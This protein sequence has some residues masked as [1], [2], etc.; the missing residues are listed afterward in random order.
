MKPEKLE[1]LV[2]CVMMIFIGAMSVDG[3]GNPIKFIREAKNAEHF[4]QSA[5]T[6]Y[7]ESRVIQEV[8]DEIE[9]QQKAKSEKVIGIPSLERIGE[10]LAKADSV[11]A[12][13]PQEA[14]AF[15]SFLYQLAMTVAGAHGSGLMGGGER[16]SEGERAF[17][18]MLKSKWK[19]DG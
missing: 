7:A 11:L 6:E 13:Q 1:V 4:F 10:Q 15:R 19:G 8:L 18:D 9:S 14:M 2:D 3:L 16:I 12:A 5:R 17:M